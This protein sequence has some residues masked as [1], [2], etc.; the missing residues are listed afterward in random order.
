LHRAL[1]ILFITVLLSACGGG[2]K[3]ITGTTDGLYNSQLSDKDNKRIQTLFFEGLKENALENYEHAEKCFLAI[4]KIDKNHGASLYHL[5]LI[6]EL[7][8][9]N[10]AALSYAKLAALI[11][12]NNE[13]YLLVLAGMYEVNLEYSEASTLYQ[14]ITTKNPKN[15]DAYYYWINTLAAEGK[16]REMIEVMDLLE[17]QM[18]FSEEL[19]MEKEKLYLRGGDVDGAIGEVEGILEKDPKNSKYLNVLAELYQKKGD[20]EK[21]LVLFDQIIALNPNDPYVHLSLSDY[22]KDLGEKEKAAKELQLAF[23]NP[24]L[25]IDPKVRIL[26]GYFTLEGIKED[27]KE[28][29]FQ[30]GHAITQTHPEEAKAHSV[31]G[32]LLYRIDSN[33]L[34]LV[35]YK[36]AIEFDDSKFVLWSQILILESEQQDFTLMYT[37]ANKAIELFPAQPTFYL[38][39]GI[40]AV[41]KKKYEEGIA[42]LN[43]GKELVYDNN[44][45]LAQFYSTLGDS[46]YK[47]K[48]NAASDSAYD[49]S[50]EYDPNN[51]YVLNNYSYYL[52]LRK[53]N[54]GK[55]EEMSKRSNDIAPRSPS[56]ADTYGWIL[57]QEGKYDDAKLWLEN[58]IDYGAAKNG[59]IL[60][61]YGDILY[62]LGDIE[63]ANNQWKNAKETNQG[64]EFLDQKIESG[65]LV[66]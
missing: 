50:L 58:A 18:G 1:F 48:D 4:I 65:K 6:M 25:G 64:S 61:H 2:S 46:Y 63:G 8:Q 26:L 47:M 33:Q 16:W 5:A 45:M 55:A 24:E 59:V 22:Y 60:E 37:D 34:A 51:V 21:A 23:E 10:E 36:K 15:V 38:F 29:A 56:F 42:A 49:K 62:K 41:Q 40:A 28:E 66:E 31:Y 14:Q 11:D 9:D 35:H 54:L 53:E 39:K 52:S 44:Q 32:D 17:G 7:K 27:K 30:L 57:Y 12:P 19:S 13:W 3:V 20:S 43:T